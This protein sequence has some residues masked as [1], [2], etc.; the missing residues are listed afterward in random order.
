MALS[1]YTVGASL[2]SVASETY[3]AEGRPEVLVHVHAVTFAVGTVA[4]VA[5]LPFDLVGV[6]GGLSLGLGVGA[7]YA[8][9]RVGRILEISRGSILAQLWPS[10]VAALAMVAALLP[11]DRLLVESETH[12]TFAALLLL[13]AE[14]ALGLAIYAGILVLLAPDTVSQVRSLIATARR[15]DGARAEEAPA[16]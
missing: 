2:I 14:G 3:K 13:G 7:V 16:T 15:R 11:L 5:L 6:V 9:A 1:V 10:A 12:A 4:M 8:L